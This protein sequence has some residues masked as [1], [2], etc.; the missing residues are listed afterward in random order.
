MRHSADGIDP[1]LVGHGDV[2]AICI[3]RYQR[4][5]RLPEV[6]FGIEV[7]HFRAHTGIAGALQDA[8]AAATDRIAQRRIAERELVIAIGMILMLARVA[9]CL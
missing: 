5:A 3:R 6:A 1:H 9:A 2:L 8:A 4:T 7:Q